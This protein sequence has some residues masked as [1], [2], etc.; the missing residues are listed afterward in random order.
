MIEVPTVRRRLLGGELR[1]LRAAAEFSL[2][3]AAQILECDRSNISRIETGHR[4]IRP[5]E[6]RELLAAYGIDERRR[7]AMADL[8]RQLTSRG[9]WQEFDQVLPRPYV[10]L[11]SLEIGAAVEWTFEAHT[12][13][14]LLQTEAYARCMVAAAG[15]VTDP[16]DRDLIVAA[17][18]MRQ[19]V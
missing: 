1:R 14:A 19:Q 6:L 11:V 8:A 18:M 7:Y 5:K 3:D 2:E 15:Q 10:D 9:W 16:R 12:V 4:G 13:P 17:R